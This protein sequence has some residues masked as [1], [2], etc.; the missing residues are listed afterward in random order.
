MEGANIEAINNRE[1]TSL[2]I[3]SN[4]G[5]LAVVKVAYL[6]LA[7]DRQ[8]SCLEAEFS[9]IVRRIKL[10]TLRMCPDVY[11]IVLKA[12]LEK[13]ARIDTRRINRPT[14][15]MIASDSDHLPVVGVSYPLSI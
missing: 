14:S 5:H 11:D 15:P 4:N 3:A 6:V 7:H 12:L 10:R 1:W 9:L 2:M 8:C 13:G